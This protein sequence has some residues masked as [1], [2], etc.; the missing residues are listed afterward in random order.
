MK[1]RAR[2]RPNSP[3]RFVDAT[4]L[5]L[6]ACGRFL[7]LPVLSAAD[8]GIPVMGL[9]SWD[10]SGADSNGSKMKKHGKPLISLDYLTPTQFEALK[11]NLK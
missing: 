7:P 6:A 9:S 2:K 1:A 11:H 8:R 3:G 4:L 5:A 10:P